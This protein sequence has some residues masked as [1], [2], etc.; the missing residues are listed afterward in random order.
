MAVYYKKVDAIQFKLTDEEKERL[1]KRE[2]VFFEGCKVKHVGGNNYIALL[3]QGENLIRIL[4][5]QWLVRNLDGSLQIYW[6]DRFSQLFTEGS[7]LEAINI[8][9]ESF[10]AKTFNQPNILL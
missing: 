6:P 5:T 4:E 8:P 2:P 1:H 9:I 7:K 10:M 3:Q